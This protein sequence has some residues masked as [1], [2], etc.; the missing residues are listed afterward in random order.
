MILSLLVLEKHLRK[1]EKRQPIVVKIR[2]MQE[3]TLLSFV[4]DQTL[5]LI[6]RVMQSIVIILL[7]IN[8]D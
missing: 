4:Q 2:F 3:E 1:L 6:L 8:L 7:N 5:I